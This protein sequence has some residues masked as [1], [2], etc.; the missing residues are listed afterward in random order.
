MTETHATLEN[1]EETFDAAD[2][3][4]EEKWIKNL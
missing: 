1:E 3:K 2:I 4:T